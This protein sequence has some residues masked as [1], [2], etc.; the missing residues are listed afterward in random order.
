MPKDYVSLALEHATRVR[1]AVESIRR[2]C[3]EKSGGGEGFLR[4]ARGFP[5]LMMASGL[6]PALTFYMAHSSEKAF[7]DSLRLV[8][9]P[10]KVDPCKAG[11]LKREL[12]D[13]EGDG[14]TLMLATLVH[15]A[16]ELGGEKLGVDHGSLCTGGG[17]EK[18]FLAIATR[19]KELRD[20]G[21]DFKLALML[22]DYIVELKKA[23]EALLKE[24]S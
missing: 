12:G 2:G 16:W 1:E 19:L 7:P 11:D 18:P 21:E 10:D 4:R 17:P 24:E 15:A 9:C 3:A 5:S 22:R 23:S 8:A 20:S 13:G 14:Y 6:V